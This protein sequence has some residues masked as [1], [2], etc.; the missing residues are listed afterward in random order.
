[1]PA[2]TLGARTA[3][4]PHAPLA[5]APRPVRHLRA[6]VT[7][8]L[9]RGRAGEGVLTDTPGAAR[10]PPDARASSV[11]GGQ[12]PASAVTQRSPTCTPPNTSG[13][14]QAGRARGDRHRG[15]GG[16]AKHTSRPRAPSAEIPSPLGGPRGRKRHT[17]LPRRRH[18]CPR[19]CPAQGTL[20]PH[21]SKRKP[22]KALEPR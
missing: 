15:P 17:A 18:S 20:L 8:P 22:D 1:M 4:H 19:G 14:R 21:E 7:V 11:L 10:S 5:S 6:T 2:L 9:L 12:Q 16:A 3:R 13:E